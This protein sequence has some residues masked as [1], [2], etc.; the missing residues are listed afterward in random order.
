MNNAAV[1]FLIATVVSLL[2]GHK[3]I[4]LLASLKVRQTISEDV[5]ERH[6]EKQ[7]TPTMG[8][9][10][11]LVGAAAGAAAVWVSHAK[12]L[13]VA[14]LTLAFAALGFIDDYLIASRGKS[15]G[16]KARHKLLGQ[17]LIAIVFVW[18]LHINRTPATT[19]VHLWGNTDV[20]LGWAYYP[21]AVLLIVWI[22]NAFNLADGLDGLVAGL[23]TIIA[24]TLGALVVLSAESGLTILAWA[25]AGGCVGFLWYNAN[26]ARIF[27]GDTG[28]L[29]LGAATAGIAIA[30]KRELLYILIAL[31]IV[32]EGLSVMI[33]VASFKLTG[34]RVFKMTPIHHHFELMGWPEQKIVVRFWLVS[35]L[36]AFTVLAG[37]GMFRIW[38]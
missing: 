7:G 35:G 6:R 36:I 11:I 18:W 15:L 24:L 29:A 21:L 10:I 34:K 31:V 3:T 4:A 9:L 2:I 13:A 20:H 23:T 16:L 19:V 26:P 33:Q 37:M 30:G 14:L 32:I 28:S 17:F 27:M 25:L 8:G 1:A 12:I 22:S 38:H 5:P